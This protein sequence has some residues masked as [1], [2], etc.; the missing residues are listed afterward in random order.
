MKRNQIVSNFSLPGKQYKYPKVSIDQLRKALKPFGISGL[1]YRDYPLEN[2]YEKGIADL[3]EAKGI[4]E[5]IRGPFLATFERADD[6]KTI[7]GTELS[8]R[9]ISYKRFLSTS[10]LRL[11]NQFNIP[12]KVEQVSEYSNE[13]SRTQLGDEWSEQGHYLRVTVGQAEFFENRTYHATTKDY[14]VYFWD[15]FNLAYAFADK[16]LKMVE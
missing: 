16:L 15:M 5:N 4:S 13:L 9:I 10:V 7:I 8:F 2:K 11:S 6:G 12:I 3:W 14:R 1:R